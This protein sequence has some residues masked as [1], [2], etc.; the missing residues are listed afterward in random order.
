MPSPSEE[1]DFA[2]VLRAGAELAPAVPAREFALRAERRGRRRVLRRRIG[3]ASAVVLVAAAGAVPSLLP[4]RAKPSAQAAAP[5]PPRVDDAFMLGTLTALLPSG[6]TVSDGQGLAPD[7]NRPGVVPQA[8]LGYDDG[9]GGRVQLLLAIDLVASPV[10]TD[11][12][13]LLCYEPIVPGSATCDPATRPD[14]SRLLTTGYGGPG[15]DEHSLSVVYTLANGRQ[16]R[17]QEVAAD[18]TVQELPLDQNELTEI[19]T[20]AQWQWV[21][22]PLGP[23]PSRPPARPAPAGDRMLAALTPLL[24]DVHLDTGRT[25]TDLPGRIRVDVTANGRTSA[26]L[27]SVTPGWRTSYPADPQRTFSAMHRSTDRRPDGTLVSATTT[28]GGVQHAANGGYVADALLPDGTEVSVRIWNSG[29]GR[30]GERPGD[31]VLTPD[32]LSALVASPV[33]STL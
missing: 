2:R 30:D 24:K 25:A 7:P 11:A 6:G 19:A 29:T 4:D 16:V 5:T 32:Q 13:R 10:T 28:L 21:F 9:R 27:L 8:Y 20:A 22:G 12:Q 23:A 15:T 1:E 3:V 14:G 26:L 17:V 18:R 33:W 31:P